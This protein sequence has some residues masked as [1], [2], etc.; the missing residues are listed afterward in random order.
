MNDIEQLN[1]RI[2]LLEKII[3]GLVFSD[4]YMFEKHVQFMDGR[5]IQFSLTTGTKIG[6]SSL[7]KIAFHGATPTVQ[8]SAIASP[9][10]GGSA[11]VDSPARTAI[12]LIINALHNKGITA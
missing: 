9:S 10:G 7:Q 6:T 12:N 11:G 1:Q 5:N 2:D 4:R 3:N 8:D